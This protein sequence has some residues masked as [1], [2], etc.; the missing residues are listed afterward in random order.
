M[1]TQL[2]TKFV[3][4]AI[5]LAANITMIGTVSVLFSGQLHAQTLALA[6]VPGVLGLFS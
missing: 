4:I 5:A 1:N 6:Q 3:A 2:S